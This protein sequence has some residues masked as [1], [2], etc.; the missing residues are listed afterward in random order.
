MLFRVVNGKVRFKRGIVNGFSMQLR[1]RVTS[2]FY[3]AMGHTEESWH[4]EI[5][6]KHILGGIKYTLNA[7]HLK[8]PDIKTR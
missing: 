5:F 3:T 6:L 2:M 7:T 1:F 4:N 8:D